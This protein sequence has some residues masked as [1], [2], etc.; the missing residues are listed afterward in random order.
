MSKVNYY[1]ELEKWDIAFIVHSCINDK[2]DTVGIMFTFFLK[3][4]LNEIK[5]IMF[6][7][8]CNQ[9]VISIVDRYIKLS[10]LQD[11]FK[12]TSE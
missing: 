1:I 5:Y 10:L 7:Y 8:I 12:K 4:K 11:T 2:I 6:E 3:I 9:F